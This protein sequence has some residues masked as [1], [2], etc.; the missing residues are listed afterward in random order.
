MIIMDWT[1]IIVAV[2]A[3]N[4]I[5]E[6]I[7]W[8]TTR[9]KP[10]PSDKLLVALAQDRVVYVGSGCIKQGYIT[11]EQLTILTSIITPYRALGGD[12]LADAIMDRCRS[13]PIRTEKEMENCEVK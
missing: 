6:V 2:I 1:S 13:L 10:K 4:G 8:L 11:R 3:S 12:G 9:K 5:V 7:K